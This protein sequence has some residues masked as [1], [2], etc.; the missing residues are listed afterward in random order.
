MRSFHLSAAAIFTLFHSA[1]IKVKPMNLS[2]GVEK[3]FNEDIPKLQH[4]NDGLIY[5]PLQSPYVVGTDPKMYVIPC[6]PPSCALF[7]GPSHRITDA[8]VSPHSL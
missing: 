8:N 1:S 4:G 5:T 2:Y 6:N 7:V 3:V